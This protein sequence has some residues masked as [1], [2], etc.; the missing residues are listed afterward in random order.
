MDKFC[1]NCEKIIA[2]HKVYCDKECYELYKEKQ[3]DKDLIE[4]KLKDNKSIKKAL[5]RIE[6]DICVICK[7]V[8]SIWNDKPLSLQVDHIDGDSDNNNYDNLRLV[9]PNCHSQLNTSKDKTK[10]ESNRN[11]YLRKYKGY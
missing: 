11:K 7:N 10:K 4:G 3:S 5:L 1:K 6:G 2:K 9:C 8:G